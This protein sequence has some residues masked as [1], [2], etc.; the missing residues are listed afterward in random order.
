MTDYQ[1]IQLRRQGAVV[2]VALNR[3]QVRNAFD[4]LMLRELIDVFTGL[5]G[6][7]PKVRV[8]VLTGNGTSF[9]A[10]ADLNWMKETVHYS[11]DENLADAG[12]VAECMHLLYRLPQPTIARINGPAIGGGMGFVCACDVA[13]AQCDAVFS[14]S[15]VRIGLVPAC[16]SPYVL[17]KIGEG[18]CRELFLSGERLSAERA[19][20]LGLVNEVVAPEALDAA[21]QRRV[22][23]LL[24]NGPHAMAACK[25]LLEK[26]AHQELEE[27]KVFTAELIAHLRAGVE[28]QEGMAAFL[29]KRTPHWRR[30]PSGGQ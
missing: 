5:A 7:F 25:V 3:P 24:A 22:E 29:E 28:A 13:V 15:E 11:V 20:A 10:G 18:R 16:I 12:R 2:T 19:H 14:L 26:V 8:V 27:A 9:C 17:K 6:D 4:A 21:V 30:D 1:T 23:Q